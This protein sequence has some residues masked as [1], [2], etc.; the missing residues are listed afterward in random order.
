MVSTRRTRSLVARVRK[1]IT[2]RVNRTVETR[3]RST[4]G[5]ETEYDIQ[6]APTGQTCDADGVR[7]KVMRSG[8]AA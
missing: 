3:E 6:S 1:P 4:A 2:Y 8:G 7:S 5:P